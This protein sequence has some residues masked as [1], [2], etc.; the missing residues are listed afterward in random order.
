[1]QGKV[2]KK[3]PLGGQN[4]LIYL[5]PF[6]R[7]PMASGMLR[8]NKMTSDLTEILLK[9]FPDVEASGWLHDFSSDC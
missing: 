6:T 2:S 9:H 4:T 1:M 3:I 8:V 5:S 7:A